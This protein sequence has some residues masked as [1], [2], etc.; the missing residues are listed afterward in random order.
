MP[1]FI[2][3]VRDY[4]KFKSDSTTQVETQVES[5]DALVYVLK[6]CLDG[7]P[8]EVVK[9][10]DD[11]S[12]IWKR[13]DEKF[14]R[15][16]LLVDVV[17]NDIRSIRT[18][19]DGNYKGFIHLVDVVEKGYADLCRLNIG[20]EMSNS[21]TVSMIEERLPTDIRRNWSKEVN[22]QDSKVDPFD[23]FP[24]FIKFLLEQKRVLEY[25]M[26]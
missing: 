19:I 7:E 16:S 5:R 26:V 24:A 25:E 20:K 9:N 10:V 22:R 18:I 6:S 2:G 13:L 3:N 11:V 12:E 23:K 4:A 17:V 21:L 8:L 1:N 14:G 15:P